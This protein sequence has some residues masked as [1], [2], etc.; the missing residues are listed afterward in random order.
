MLRN[1][2]KS[3]YSGLT[4]ILSNPS[5]FDKE[6]KPG[7]GNL[8][9]ATGGTLFG[10]ILQ[11][12]LNSMMCDVRVMEDKSPWLEG[13]KCILLLGE[14]AM[15]EYALDTRG[16]TLNEMR[17]SLLSVGGIPAIASYPPQDAADMKNYEKTHN[18]LS[19][20]Y[21]GDDE[22]SVGDEDDEGDVKRFSPTKRSNYAFW[23]KKDIEKCKRILQNGVQFRGVASSDNNQRD[24]LPTY[25]IYPTADEVV[26]ILTTTKNTHFY[27][28]METDYEEQ[29]LLCFAFSFDGINIYSVPILNNDY[30]PA[31]TNYHHILRAL[32]IAIRDN[33]IVAHNGACFDF[34]VLAFKYHIPVYRCYDTM[35]A[36][37]RCFPSVEKSLGHCVSLWTWERFHKDNNP[38]CYLTREHMSNMLKYC[39]KDV[40][41]MYLVKQGIDKYAKT[42]PGL[43]A[44]IKCAQDSIVPYL[45]MS[46][47]GIAFD[48]QA[49][50]AITDENDKL[51][52]QY[53]RMMNLLIGDKGL[54]EMK[55]HIKSFK[56]NF[57]GGNKQACAYF[58]NLLEYP[59]LFRSPQS[60]LPSLGKKIMYRL[61]MK[62]PE[63]A[64]IPIILKYRKVQ[65]E[66]S[67]LKFIPFRDDKGKVYYP[68]IEQKELF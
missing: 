32:A 59:V 11:P 38:G 37:H 29:N 22:V 54:V 19:K 13:T 45:L 41:T 49:R 44:S 34:F 21:E 68:P 46:L 58:H 16:N 26:H 50:K 8:L 7:I 35:L 9:S 56:G 3:R 43:E 24:I 61:A 48:E 52:M 20:D 15:H 6:Y 63:N 12:E 62:Y 65:K 40:Y 23:L 66:T 57:T 60:G 10:E 27:F 18:E 5:R 47:Q 42:I 30:R 64:V 2:P 31:Y 33:I 28:D 53:I 14:H 67:A 1:K 55:D 17:G 36:Q 4:I 25:Y 39:A 51:M